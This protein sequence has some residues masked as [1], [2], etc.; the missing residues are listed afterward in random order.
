MGGL[1]QQFYKNRNVRKYTGICNVLF[2]ITGS[3]HG[4]IA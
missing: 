2:D 3:E 1:L 4:K